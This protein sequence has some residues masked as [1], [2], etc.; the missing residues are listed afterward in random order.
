MD[1]SM[2]RTLITYCRNISSGIKI[3]FTSATERFNICDPV[4]TPM[5]T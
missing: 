1:K 2:S 4:D 3:T 5:V